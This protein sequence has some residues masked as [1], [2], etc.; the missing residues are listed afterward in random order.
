[1]HLIGPNPLFNFYS[2]PDLHN[3]NDVIAYIDQGGLSL[4][5]RDYYL[6]D[7]PK[8][9]DARKSLVEYATQMFTLAGQSPQQAADSAQT[10]LRIETALAK[11]SMDRTRAAIP[12]IRDHKMTREEAL[13][14]GAQF[15]SEPLFC[16]YRAPQLFQ[17]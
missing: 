10:V 7:D 15:L 8:M 6:K 11:A 12:R 1:M 16:G 4:P 5:D 13:A 14:P 2:S 9:A 17:A 3:A